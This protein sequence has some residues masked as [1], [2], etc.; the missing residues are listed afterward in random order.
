MPKDRIHFK[1]IPKTSAFFLDY[2]HDFSK[3]APFFP[4]PYALDHFRKEGASVALPHRQELCRILEK[5]NRSFGAGA[6]TLENVEK[7]RD[8]DCFAVVTGQQVGLFTGPA[9]T[10]YK[11]LS[12]IRMAQRTFFMAQLDQRRLHEQVRRLAYRVAPVAHG[13]S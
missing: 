4:F 10:I 5:Q 7:L 13:I 6:R 9:Y 2:L 8:R 11:A 12:A 3:L 1:D